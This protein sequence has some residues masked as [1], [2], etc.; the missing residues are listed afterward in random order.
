[1]RE[2][3]EREAA[4]KNVLTETIEGNETKRLASVAFTIQPN[5]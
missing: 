3:F 2:V 1:M 4:Y 5:N